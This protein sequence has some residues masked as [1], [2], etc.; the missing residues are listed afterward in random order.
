MTS[1]SYVDSSTV[2]NVENK[3]YTY[4]IHEVDT[5]YW[6]RGH[7]KNVQERLN[8]LQGA[9]SNKLVIKRTGLFDDKEEAKKAEHKL[10]LFASKYASPAPGGREWFSYSYE[11]RQ[12]L[13]D[14]FEEICNKLNVVSLE[15]SS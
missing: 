4:L 3:Y 12:K 15:R 2:D 5:D 11:D 1:E 13:Y 9:N 6:K 10:D 7:S 8:S 14:K